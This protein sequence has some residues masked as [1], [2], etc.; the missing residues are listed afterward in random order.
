[1]PA[2]SREKGL[3]NS[4]R[5]A[6]KNSELGPIPADWE[7]STLGQVIANG[8]AKLQTGPFGTVLKASEFVETGHPVVSVRE[9]R[10]GYIQ[11]YDDTPC[12]SDE[13]YEKLGKYSLQAE[14]LVFARKGSV[15]RSALI[16]SGGISYFLGSDSI[17]LRMDN[18]CLFPKYLLYYLQLSEIKQHVARH[19]YGTT[20]AGLNEAS[21]RTIPLVI[22]PLPEQ[23]RIA[24]ALSDAD[25]WIESLDKLI[26][27]KKLVKQGAMQA[28]LSGKTRLPGFSG[29]WVEKRLGDCMIVNPPNDRMIPETFFYIDLESVTK[30]RLAG[31]AEIQKVNAPSRA[32]RLFQKGDILFQTVRPYQNNNLFVDFEAK[33]FV[34]STGYA[35]L[36][37]K[38]DTDA[39]WMFEIIQTPQFADHVMD[40]C[41]GTGYPAINP[42]KLA[43]I[44][45]LMP[46]SLAEQRGIAAILSDMDAELTS[47]SR[48]KAKA[49]RIKE[50]M[51]QELL[52][53]KTRLKGEKRSNHET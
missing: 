31:V 42:G 38:C 45:F 44:P 50:G 24:A 19:A 36:R 14:D 49:E 32:Q 3:A 53:G 22:P 48:E 43:E 25:A 23:Q 46:P 9:I 35:I 20:M 28:L 10:S 16:P 17:G 11:L 8:H 41:T 5:P 6:F 39:R 21:L 7:V 37:A 4:P 13:T 47:L 33:Q 51:M 26:E 40:N 2:Y 29:K 30:G 52:T 12:V 15:E 34:A 1:M 27:K 18:D